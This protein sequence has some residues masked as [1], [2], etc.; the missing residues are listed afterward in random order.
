MDVGQILTVVLGGSSVIGVVVGGY[1]KTR[2]DRLTAEVQKHKDDNESL[3][4]QVAAQATAGATV[5]V[6]REAGET[7]REQAS[8]QLDIQR[9][10]RALDRIRELQDWND[11]LERQNAQNYAA[12]VHFIDLAVKFAEAVPS[13]KRTP[14]M[15]TILVGVVPN[16]R[17]LPQ[18]GER[19]EVLRGPVTAVATRDVV[20]TVVTPTP[21]D[22]VPGST[23]D[24]PPTT[25]ES[26][27]TP[28]ARPL[29]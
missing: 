24:P 5:E 23:D 14:E 26:P 25:P 4:A 8:G 22:P 17:L 21:P 27:I 3:K 6:A 15:Q 16:E 12:A 9:G 28:L 13:D 1:F 20:T 18:L 29:H 11:A 2:S 19:P 7:Q 10:E